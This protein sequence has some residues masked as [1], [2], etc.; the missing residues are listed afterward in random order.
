MCCQQ[1]L[2]RCMRL[3]LRRRLSNF[4]VICVPKALAPLAGQALAIAA[5]SFDKTPKNGAVSKDT[6]PFYLTSFKYIQGFTY[7]IK[8]IYSIF[9]GMKIRLF[10]Y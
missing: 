9:E 5:L 1:I 2:K 10:W 4:K 3:L 8:Y 6:A 7:V